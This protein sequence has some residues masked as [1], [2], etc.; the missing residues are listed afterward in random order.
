MTNAGFYSALAARSLPIAQL[1]R[2]EY[3]CELPPDWHI[4]IADIRNST[5]AVR[6]GAQNDVNLVAAGSLIA[7]LNI[8]RARNIEVPFFFGGDG[9]TFIVPEEMLGELMAALR[10]HAENSERNFGMSLHLGAVPVRSVYEGGHLLKLN[11]TRLGRGFSKAV[12]IGDGLLWAERQVKGL[13]G[14]D[15]PVPDADLDMMGLECRWDRIAPPLSGQQVVCY[16]IEA[17]DPAQQLEVYREVLSKAD[18]VFGTPELRNPLSTD[19]LRLLLSARKMRREMLARFGHWKLRYLVTELCRTAVARVLHGS[20][21]RL[22]GFSSA[23]YLKEVISNA[24]TLTVDGRINTIITGTV[25][26][27]R[28]FLD[29]LDGAEAAGRLRYGYH[30]NRES[31]MTC[32]IESRDQRHIHFV[33]GSDGGYTAAAGVLK[34]KRG[35]LQ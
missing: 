13:S 23:V 1:M 9:G 7:G 18:A 10:V 30:I 22:G 14:Q 29:Y 24:D 6:G 33:D 21:A 31:I 12:I 34:G 3:F 32:Y 27:C 25:E 20:K 19:R 26:Q 16:L 28:R 35:D 11:K 4:V 15:D 2:G 5:A 17:V 8:A